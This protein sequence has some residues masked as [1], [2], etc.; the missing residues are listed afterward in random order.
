M[1]KLLIANRGEIAVRIARACA[2]HGVQSVAV[3][4]DADLNALHVRMADEAYGLEGNKPADTYL[5]I[6]KLLAVAERSGAD[7][8]HPGYGFLSESAAFAQ[9]VIDAGLT[10]VGPS[11]AAIAMLGDKVQARKLAMK[12][13]APLVAGTADPVKNAGEVLAF[14]EK[15]GLPVAIKAAFGGGGRGIKVAWRLDEVEGLYESAV[16]EAVTAFGRGECYVEQFLDRPRHVEAQVLADT[17]GNVVVLGTRDCSLQRRNQKLVEEA[18]APFLSDAQRERIHQAAR[19]ICAEAGYTGAGTVEFMLSTTG[20]ISFLEVNTRLQVEHP[21]TEET[22]GIDL[23]IEQLRVADGLPLSITQ[24]PVPRGH[25]F[26]FRINAEDVGRGFLPSPG[27]VDV[28]EAPSGPG[29]RVDAGVDSGSQ[30]P[31]TFDSLMAKLIVTGA[32]REQAIARARRA[33]KEFRIEGLPTVLPFHRAVMAHP[34]FVSGDVFKVHTRWIETDF[35][36]GEAPAL[37]PDPLPDA[38]LL[39]TAIE[40]DGRRM[41]LGLPAVLLSGLSSAAGGAVAAPAAQAPAADAAAVAA[42]V[43]G[44]VQ[45]WKVADGDEVAEG[46]VIAVM[47]AMKMEMQVL[48]HRAGRIAF[49]VAAG[50]YVAAGTAIAT[51]G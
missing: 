35:A 44:T 11:P 46:A 36:N 29:V 39:R 9:A 48:A 16:R 12:V 20:A 21:V 45:G 23:V 13:G 33:L 19:D 37:R 40:V 6:A 50:G 30:V 28:F 49:A 38:A 27:P 31:G 42:P 26:E 8:V 34:D 41:A 14:A 7:A 47:E 4:A 51:I 18:P 43:S 25:S 24:T 1:K 17:H 10:W 22:T 2:D 5:N 15:H 32:T 3:Y